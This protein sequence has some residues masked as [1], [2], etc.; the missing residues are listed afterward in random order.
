MEEI[1]KKM[2]KKEIKEQNKK[3]KEEYLSYLN[4]LHDHFKIL[5][6]KS[7]E[8]CHTLKAENSVMIPRHPER[9]EL[10]MN[11]KIE[12]FHLEK[13]LSALKYKMKEIEDLIKDIMEDQV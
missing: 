13:L 2:K 8:R 4:G 3:R 6:E 10:I 7:E 1:K 11:N 12:I 5:F 9:E